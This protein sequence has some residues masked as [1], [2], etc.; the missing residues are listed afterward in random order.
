MSQSF[1]TINK[2]ER[3]LQEEMD[4]IR[5]KFANWRVLNQYTASGDHWY[6]LR[7]F[8]PIVVE[9]ILDQDNKLWVEQSSP[10]LN[11]SCYKKSYTL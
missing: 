7:I 2:L 11:V 10:F 3:K 6:E 9:W 8:R 5:A 1:D 4:E